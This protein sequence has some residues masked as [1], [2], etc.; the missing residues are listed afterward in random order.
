M[1]IIADE[2]HHLALREGYA[3]TDAMGLEAVRLL[4]SGMTSDLCT[5]LAPNIRWG[6]TSG[7]F[8][9]RVTGW[10]LRDEELEVIC[11]EWMDLGAE[12]V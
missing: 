7:G 4:A 11:E 10:H 1:E 2:I 3:L 6:A 12:H 8:Q 9:F 5:M